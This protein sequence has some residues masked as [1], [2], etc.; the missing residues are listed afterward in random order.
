MATVIIQARLGSVRLP[1]KV[2][3]L[4]PNNKRIID[5]IIE[6]GLKSNAERTVLVTPDSE[7]ASTVTACPVHLW[8]GPRDVL[9]EFWFAAKEYND[10]IVRLTG[11]CPLLTPEI[12]NHMLDEYTHSGVDY[13][14]NTH[15]DSP[16]CDGYDVEIFSL[17]SLKEAFNEAET[18]YEREHVT[19]YIREYFK[20]KHITMNLAEGCSV[21][22]VS[23]YKRVCEIMKQADIYNDGD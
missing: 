2:E 9:G 15:D 1:R 6:A 23:D 13:V 8:A 20:T 21:N 19:P 11:D 22:T 4:L 14:C 3:L 16:A 10:D 12:I 17:K 5:N 7:L 18:E